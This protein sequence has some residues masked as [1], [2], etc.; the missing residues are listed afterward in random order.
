MEAIHTMTLP[1]A[2]RAVIKPE[3][4]RDYLLSTKHTVGRFKAAFFARLGYSRP[5]WQQL[6]GDIRGIAQIGTAVEGQ[7]SGILRGPSGRQASVKT[8]RIFKHGEDFQTLVT[9]YPGD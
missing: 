7:P 3:K 5:Q 8:I 6:Q 4:V 1:E 2:D 9:V